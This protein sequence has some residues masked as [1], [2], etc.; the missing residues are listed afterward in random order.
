FVAAKLIGETQRAVYHAVF[1]EHKGVV[2]GTAANQAHGA[3]GLNVGFKAER[4]RARKNLGERF[5]V[6]NPFPL[7]LGDEGVRKI[8]EATNTKFIGRIDADAA[9]VI[10]DFN[11]LA[12]LEV[13][14]LAAKAPDARLIKQ[15]HKWFGR[16]VEDGNLDVVNINENVV[17]PVG[18]GRG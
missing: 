13:A 9:S 10:D 2:Q 7:R 17:N 6:H 3:G 18:I 8:H 1:G 16:A 4:A 15:L 12:D 14:A 5:R 11:R